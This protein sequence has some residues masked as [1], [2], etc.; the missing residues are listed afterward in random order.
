MHTG[1]P[2]CGTLLQ[3]ARKIVA[4]T[5]GTLQGSGGIRDVLGDL[6]AGDLIRQLVIICITACHVVVDGDNLSLVGLGVLAELNSLS[7]Y[8]VALGELNLGSED[9]I[10][11]RSCP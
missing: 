8:R 7:G 11:G 2:G 4:D 9:Q 6:A 5:G 1:C 10:L 3:T